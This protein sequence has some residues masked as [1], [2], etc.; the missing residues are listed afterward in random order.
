MFTASGVARR[1]SG[2]EGG[3][4][5]GRNSLSVGMPRLSITGVA[6]GRATPARNP[7]GVANYLAPPSAR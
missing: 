2:A 1:Q 7:L 5:R 3:V 6:G 4:G